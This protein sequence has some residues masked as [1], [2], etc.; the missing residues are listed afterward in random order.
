MN[1][2]TQQKIRIT[3]AGPS[4]WESGDVGEPCSVQTTD[5]ALNTVSQVVKAQI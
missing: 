2:A 4:G 1:K 5:R 3:A